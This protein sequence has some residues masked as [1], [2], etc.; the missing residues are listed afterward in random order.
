MSRHRQVLFAAVSG[1]MCLA[2]APAQS[3]PLRALDFDLWCGEEMHFPVE[4][5]AQRLPDD[6]KTFEAYRDTIEAYENRDRRKKSPGLHLDS[7]FSDAPTA[8]GARLG[9]TP[10]AIP[11]PGAE[12]PK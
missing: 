6:I 12:P 1:L 8:S 2:P 7:L 5:C 3:V 9:S 4:R 11:Q 10:D